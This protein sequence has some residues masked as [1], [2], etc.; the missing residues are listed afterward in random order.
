NRQL[1]QAVSYARIV[2]EVAGAGGA[3]V[4]EAAPEATVR[5]ERPEQEAREASRRV[6][7][8]LPVEPP[9]RFRERG[10]QQTV[11]GGDRLVVASGLRPTL[12]DLEQP[13]AQVGIELPADHRAPVLERVQELR[14]NAL[15]LRPGEREPLDPV[16]VGV[17]RGGEA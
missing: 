3:A 1:V 9:P 10:E 5:R 14:R 4:A 7:P 13:R 16:G 6:Q 17:L 12:P 15:L 8:V 2:L 11:P